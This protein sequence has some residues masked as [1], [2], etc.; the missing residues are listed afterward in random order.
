MD[1]D[2]KARDRMYERAE[3]VAGALAAVGDELRDAIA[4]VN[5]SAEANLGDRDTT[6]GKA[7]RVLN[8]QLQALTNIEARTEELERRLRELQAKRQPGN[9]LDQ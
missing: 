5:S 2:A 1:D 9:D 8:N 3:E 6:L 7:V 4:D